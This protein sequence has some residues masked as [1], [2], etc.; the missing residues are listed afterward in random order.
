M[1][2]L[3][4]VAHLNLLFWPKND[5]QD[6]SDVSVPVKT[7]HLLKVYRRSFTFKIQFNDFKGKTPP[8]HFQEV[9]GLNRN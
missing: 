6:V 9:E 1:Q 7:L 2:N 4:S 3:E 8:I 5:L